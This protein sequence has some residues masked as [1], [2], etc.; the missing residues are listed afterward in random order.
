MGSGKLD[1]TD[2]KVLFLGPQGR[3]I[4]LT[5]NENGRDG[6]WQQTYA[7]CIID[8]AHVQYQN[9]ESAGCGSGI[10]V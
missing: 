10:F 1:T 2:G 7:E 8:G 6:V 4:Q 5:E 3:S 9:Q